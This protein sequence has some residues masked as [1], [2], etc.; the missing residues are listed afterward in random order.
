MKNNNFQRS[1]LSQRN[2]HSFVMLKARQKQQTNRCKPLTWCG[3][4]QQPQ[5]VHGDDRRQA[6]NDVEYCDPHQCSRWHG[7]EKGEQ[8]GQ[9]K[10][11]PAVQGEYEKDHPPAWSELVDTRYREQHLQDGIGD[12]Q[13][14]T[15]KG[16]DTTTTLLLCAKWCKT[17]LSG[18]PDT[19]R[20]PKAPD[21]NGLFLKTRIP[22]ARPSPKNASFECFYFKKRLR[23]KQ[24]YSVGLVSAVS[25]V[26]PILMASFLFLRW[27]EAILS[28]T[29]NP[30]G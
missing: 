14:H 26:V 17:L 29:T 28:M 7:K 23:T 24:N 30:N 15:I 1:K 25:Y 11:G 20:I 9:W 2:A 10:G 16:R 12:V 18:F 27:Q 5:N 6:G 21:S 8:V 3:Q 19:A 13:S 4:S 22:N